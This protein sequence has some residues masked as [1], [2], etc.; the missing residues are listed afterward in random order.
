M[1]EEF[2]VNSARCGDYTVRGIDGLFDSRCKFRLEH[3]M[4]PVE[5]REFESLADACKYFETVVDKSPAE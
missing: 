1:W 5:V 4:T 3:C 2:G